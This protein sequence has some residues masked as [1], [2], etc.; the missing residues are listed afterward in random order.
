M[1]KDL[2]DNPDIRQAIEGEQQNQKHY[3]VIGQSTPP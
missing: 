2:L 3:L 1:A